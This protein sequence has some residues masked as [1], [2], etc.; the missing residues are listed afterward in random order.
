MKSSGDWL[1]LRIAAQQELARR[2]PNSLLDWT[3]AYRF[4][5][6]RPMDLTPAFWDLYRDDHPFIVIQKA[7]QVFVS[8][9][10]I[11]TALWVADTGQGGRGNALYVMPTQNQMDDFSQARFDK[12]IGES[13][14]LQGR[15]FPPPPGRAGPSRQRLKKLGCGY[16]YFR[17]AESQR[18]L[19]SVDADVVIL[20]EY[21]QMGEGTLALAQKRVASSHLGFLRLASTPGLPEAGI[22]DLFLQSDQRYYFL[23]CPGCGYA[24]RLTWNENVDQKRGLLVCERKRCRKLMDLW[25]DGRWEA[26]APGNQIRG[27]HLSRLYSPLA[28]VRQMVYESEAT[29]P[30]A[31]RLFNNAVLGE[32]FVPPGGRL[33]LDVLDRCRHDYGMPDGSAEG[34]FMGVDVGVKLHVVIRQP[35]DEDW[36]RSRAVFIAEVDTFEELSQLI[37]R[38]AVRSA[39]VDAQPDQHSAAEFARRERTLRPALAYYSRTDPG[40]SLGS[41][42]G[43]RVCHLNRTETLEEMFHSFQTEAA[44]LPRVARSLAGRVRD[45]LGEYYRQMMAPTR[46]LEENAAGNWIARFVNN[47]KADHFAHAENYCRVAAK[48]RR[49]PVKFIG[50]SVGTSPAPHRPPRTRTRR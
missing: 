9:Y 39:V 11:N 23:K 28:D 1:S 47:G 41:V 42:N 10:L 38:Y 19:T 12:A 21:D 48:I 40:H 37:D 15:L 30:A 18:Q 44:E 24:Q 29:T 34:T 4:L 43:I 26:A 16:I 22:S 45:G 27:Y 25:G 32:T 49:R 8:E 35:L 14:Y 17:G 33:T 13:E 50:G 20:D 36:A 3:L 7:A 6:G 2:N 31:M 46:R 5:Q